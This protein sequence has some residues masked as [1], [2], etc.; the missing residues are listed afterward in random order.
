MKKFVVLILS[1]VSAVAFATR[2]TARTG[3]PAQPL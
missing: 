2:E 3:L 1:F